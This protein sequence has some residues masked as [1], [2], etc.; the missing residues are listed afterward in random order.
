MK[1][2]MH[3]SDALLLHPPLPAISTCHSN[4]NV[5]L[6]A[7]LASCFLCNKG[8]WRKFFY[9]YCSAVFTCFLRNV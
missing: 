4:C 5:T 3:Y 2:A 6:F 1:P 9:G 7:E 8:C